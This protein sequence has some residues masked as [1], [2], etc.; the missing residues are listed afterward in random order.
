MGSSLWGLLKICSF[1]S[2]TVVFAASLGIFEFPGSSALCSPK[3]RP[4]SMWEQSQKMQWCLFMT[5]EG[6]WEP[7][8]RLCF[9]VETPECE[10][11]AL[12]W[13]PQDADWGWCSAADVRGSFCLVNKRRS[14]EITNYSSDRN[15]WGLSC[16]IEWSPGSWPRDRWF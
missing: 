12:Q 2:N 10:F 3:S 13:Y 9:I 8:L 14:R 5:T 1:S 11:R 4:C 16:W 15:K 7:L 6:P